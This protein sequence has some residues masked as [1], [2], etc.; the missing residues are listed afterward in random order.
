M[1]FFLGIA[2]K[3]LLKT[4]PSALVRG[5]RNSFL[6]TTHNGDYLKPDNKELLLFRFVSHEP[7][8]G[9]ESKSKS[10]KSCIIFDSII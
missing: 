9:D 7:G 8:Q 4:P 10:L 1:G 3:Q 5:T 6:L 2:L